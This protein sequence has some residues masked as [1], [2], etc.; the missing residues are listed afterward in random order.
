MLK[1]IN[2]VYPQDE[3]VPFSACAYCGEDIMPGYEFVETYGHDYCDWD[4]LKKQ[5]IKDDM[6]KEKVAGEN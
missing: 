6:C 2:E 1:D 3:S 4:C 5:L